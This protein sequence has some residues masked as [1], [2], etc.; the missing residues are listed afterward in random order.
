MSR[1][2]GSRVLCVCVRACMRTCVHVCLCVC[3]FLRVGLRDR[4][5]GVSCIQ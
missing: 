4:G 1:V 3:V 2:A 5:K